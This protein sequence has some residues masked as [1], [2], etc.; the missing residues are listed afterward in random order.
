MRY[1][2]LLL[3]ASIT[4]LAFVPTEVSAVPIANLYNTG[5]DSVG[6][7]LPT[8]GLEAHYSIFSSPI[9]TFT[10]VAVDN[11]VYPFPLWVANTPPISRWIGTSAQSSDGPGGNY[12]YR[13]SFNLPANANLSTVVITAMWASDDLGQVFVNTLPSGQFSAGHTTLVPLTLTNN[14][15]VGNNDIDFVV[16]N[17]FGPTGL[18]VEGI[19]GTFS[20]PEPGSILL[21][22]LCMGGVSLRR[23]L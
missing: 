3:I 15:Q 5:L 23:R 18:R 13:T 14:F 20:I 4:Q 2:A 17:A 8:F 9:G 6:N 12:V 11:T 7:Y 19:K 16:N 21:V 10:P 1:L 22:A